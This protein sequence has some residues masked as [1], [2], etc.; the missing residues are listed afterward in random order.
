MRVTAAHFAQIG[1][2]P[3]AESAIRLGFGKQSSN[4]RRGHMLV[5]DRP[6][7]RELLGPRGCPARRHDCGGVP[8]EH[9]YCFLETADPA[10]SVF[11]LLIGGHPDP[12]LRR[13][14]RT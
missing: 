10:E 1:A 11:Q 2:L 13:W 9:R 4:L 8:V 7:S 12:E 14:K 6:Q 3:L 5:S